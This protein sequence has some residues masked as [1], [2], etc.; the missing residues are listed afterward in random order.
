M[1][2]RRLFIP[3]L[4]IIIMIVA[5]SCSVSRRAAS[6]YQT[7]SQRAQVTLTFDQHQYSMSSVVRVWHNE[8]AVVSVQPMLGIEMV[9]ME[10]TPDSV[11]VFD[12]MN[13]RY[14]VLS[15]PE[16]E[17][18]LNTKISYK[19]IQDF[20]SHQTTKDKKPIQMHFTSG[21]HQLKLSC[22]FS[23]RESNTLQAPTR[24][25]TAKYQQVTIR[26]ILPLWN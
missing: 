19:T 25:K 11:W 18:T 9:R 16:I 14:V 24:T 10:A 3:I 5:S 26:E 22:T 4:L 6:R 17:N 20:L 15:Y 21:K 2:I 8:L 7:L 23:N 13:R 1:Q 12:K